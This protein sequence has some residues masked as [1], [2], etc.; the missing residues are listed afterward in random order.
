MASGM[1][2]VSRHW[3]NAR[4]LLAA[5][6]ADYRGFLSAHGGNDP[7]STQADTRGETDHQ[8]VNTGA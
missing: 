4:H 2:R 1:E 5:Q 8:R 7:I 6:P 3:H